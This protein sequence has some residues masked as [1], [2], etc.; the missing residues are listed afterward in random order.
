MHTHACTH[1]HKHTHAH[2]HAHTHTLGMQIHMLFL[3]SF[4]SR[5]HMRKSY[6]D[7]L[8]FSKEDTERLVYYSIVGTQTCCF[9]I[10][11]HTQYNFM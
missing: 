5:K 4:L 11:K 10:Y 2:T 1:V 8:M 6:G 9:T 7:P 3:F